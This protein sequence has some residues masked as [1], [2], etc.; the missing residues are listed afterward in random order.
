MVEKPHLTLSVGAV[1]CDSRKKWSRNLA[2]SQI[3]VDT[4]RVWKME[5]PPPPADPS[6][7]RAALRKKTE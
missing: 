1:V 3:L 5:Y 6:E 7:L 4:M 2:V